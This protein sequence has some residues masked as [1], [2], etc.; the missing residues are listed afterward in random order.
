MNTK[1]MGLAGSYR[2][3]QKAMLTPLAQAL[4]K[5][6][7]LETGMKKLYHNRWVTSTYFDSFDFRLF[8]QSEEGVTPRKKIRVRFYG[9]AA[10]ETIFEQKE[11]IWGQRKKFSEPLSNRDRERILANG[12]LD[13]S[14]GLLRAVS[15]VKYEREY[16]RL[17]N[18]RI[19]F[20]NSIK[21]RHPSY[22]IWHNE[23]FTVVE[24]KFSANE[25]FD[26]GEIPIVI[27]RFSKYCRSI[28]CV[29]GIN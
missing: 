1:K 16:F 28:K 2:N 27:S 17:G 8:H 15:I 22:E 3:E 18:T 7:L 12:L 23:P 5:K 10:A 19:T 13:H 20:D 21:Y 29:Y 24:F 14:V 4:L 26:K 6:Q 25:T 11:T 9:G